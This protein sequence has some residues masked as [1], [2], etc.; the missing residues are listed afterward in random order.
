MAT[1]FCFVVALGAIANGFFKSRGPVIPDIAAELGLKPRTV[2]LTVERA[3]DARRAIMQ[4][5]YGAAR[6]IIAAEL[7]RSKMEAWRFYPFT[8][9]IT[10]ISDVHDPAYGA[11]IETWAKADS[12]DALP[13]LLQA[14]YEHDIAWARRGGNYDRE[15][16]AAD[17]DFF[18]VHMLQANSDIDTALARNDSNPYTVALKLRI[19]H[20]L[21][22]QHASSAM[23]ETAIAKY[24]SYY[25][26]YSIVLGT[27][28]PKWGGSVRAMRTFVDTYA[29][30][31]GATSPLKMLY[32]EL[33]DYFIG[34]SWEGCRGQ[35]L[36]DDGMT[37]CVADGMRD[38]GASG[39]EGGVVSALGLYQTANKVQYDIEVASLLQQMI[40]TGGAG[41]FSGA[42]L[43]LAAHAT[44]SDTQLVEDRANHRND[45]MIDS[46]VGFSWSVKTD[47]PD[48][49]RK[50]EEALRDMASA[51]FPDEEA[52]DHAYASIFE[53]L[54]GDYN[55]LNQFD[56]VIAYERAA[57]A[58]GGP[59]AYEHLICNAYIQLQAYQEAVD[60]CTPF[61]N[62][63][64]GI[65]SRYWRA[66]AYHYLDQR[67]AE[68]ADFRV[69]A[70]SE[71]PTFRTPALIHLSV[72]Y[73][74]Q[75]AFREMIDLLDTHP[76]AFDESSQRKDD[77]ATV[78]NNRCYAYMQLGELRKALD[79]CTASLRFGSIP[80][81]YHKQQELVSRLAGA[82]KP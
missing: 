3:A 32:L 51:A 36:N 4:G 52:K 30:Q 66:V 22:E 70:D 69:I 61:I 78:Y 31:A 21:G 8:D 37:G 26:L 5:D 47:Y 68:A 16:N 9:F 45:Y 14:Q 29:G 63:P 28:Q 17:R 25:A 6:T 40:R 23:L 65:E 75:K 11:R 55:K 18:A 15:T 82:A 50:Y 74:D 58:Y 12:T 44:G 43:Q 35:K 59:S 56:K 34:L 53:G 7:A 42:L 80:D 49:I 60:T 13:L 24:P 73:A 57:V 76:F 38:L 64:D 54:A 67:D 62:D 72:Y 1:A 33:Y 41:A 27:L 81:A 2:E 77:L 79:D 71:N 46:L 48:A 10:H 19:L 39:L 20:S